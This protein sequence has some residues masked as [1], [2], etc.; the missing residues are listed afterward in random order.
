MAGNPPKQEKGGW[1]HCEIQLS[2]PSAP[3]ETSP[4]IP[5]ASA[6]GSGSGRGGGS[7]GY[8]DSH[9]EEEILGGFLL[10]FS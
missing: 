2:R 1:K 5:L 10:S 4:Q 3:A 8:E 6:S 9:N 7:A